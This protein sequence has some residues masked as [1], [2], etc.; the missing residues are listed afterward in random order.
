MSRCMRDSAA[1][2]R[3]KRERK[4]HYAVHKTAQDNAS[5]EG[6]YRYEGEEPVSSRQRRSDDSKPLRP[7]KNPSYVTRHRKQRNEGE[8]RRPDARDA[9]S[10]SRKR[11]IF[12]GSRSKQRVSKLTTNRYISTA[13]VFES[14]WIW[15]SADG[16]K[17]AESLLC[18]RR[19]GRPRQSR[20][21]PDA[22][23]V[24]RI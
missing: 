3:G 11:S 14:G 16:W 19:T 22:C 24:Q 1:R 9:R 18:A 7:E 10:V 17:C 12:I 21:R 8:S 23:P 4:H 20:L 13:L 6:T 5:S 2:M 15:R